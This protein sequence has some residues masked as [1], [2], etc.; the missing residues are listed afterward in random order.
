MEKNTRAT[1]GVNSIQNLSKQI[2]LESMPLKGDMKISE[3]SNIQATN[4]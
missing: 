2:S 1:T 3:V 4:E